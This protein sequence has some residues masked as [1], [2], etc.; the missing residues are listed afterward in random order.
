M[1]VPSRRRNPII[2]DVFTR[3][4]Y[5]E[6]RGSGFK[7]I[8]E[9]YQFQH[10]YTEE[11]APAFRSEHGSFF[12]TLKNLNYYQNSI[13]TINGGI[14]G[15]INGEIN[16]GINLSETDNQILAAIIKNPRITRSDLAG[17]LG[18]GTS[19]VD[20][21]IKKLKDMDILTRIGSNK[22]GYWDVKKI[23]C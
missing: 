13:T 10:N 8:I 3:L 21:T 9:D 22:S 5:M 16:G 6:R 4:I 15:G 1:T 14:N 20:R 12:L 17:N 18:F 2:A 23:G 7:K 11:L 19:T